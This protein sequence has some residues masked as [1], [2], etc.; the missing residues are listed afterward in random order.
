MWTHTHRSL[1][2]L[3]C[4]HSSNTSPGAAKRRWNQQQQQNYCCPSS[5]LHK[6]SWL[7][8]NR[9]IH[10]G[11]LNITSSFDIIVQCSTIHVLHTFSIFPS[12]LAV[13][14]RSYIHLQ[15]YKT[16]LGSIIIPVSACI[17]VNILRNIVRLLS[18]PPRKLA[19]TNVTNWQLCKTWFCTLSLVLVVD[20]DLQT[21]VEFWLNQSDYESAQRDFLSHTQVQHI[22]LLS[23]LV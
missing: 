23:A 2:P 16:Q 9:D 4:S 18:P 19:V 6:S 20:V 14:R 22:L 5:Y 15:H 10:S 7:P 8:A 17:H 12:L 13:N 21:V 1:I 3:I 11:T